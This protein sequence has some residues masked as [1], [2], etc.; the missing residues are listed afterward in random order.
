[1]CTAAHLVVQPIGD[2]KLVAADD[3][4]V[5]D[6]SQCRVTHRLD[7]GGRWMLCI[8]VQAV[9]DDAL[10]FA[11]VL[12]HKQQRIRGAGLAVDG[13]AVRMVVDVRIVHTLNANGLA[14]KE[15]GGWR[16]GGWRKVEKDKEAK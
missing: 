12:G 15:C 11:Q 5:V 4:D 8:D 3:G 6:L 14:W 9:D 7:I 13:N 16:V 2:V 10:A 1:M